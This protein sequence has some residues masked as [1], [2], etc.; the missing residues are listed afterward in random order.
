MVAYAG[1]A[2]VS[3]VGVGVLS[4]LCDG[5]YSGAAIE[6]GHLPVDKDGY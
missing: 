5:D 4:L 1:C 2:G 3:C 6:R